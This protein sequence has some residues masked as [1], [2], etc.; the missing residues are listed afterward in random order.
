MSLLNWT[1][2]WRS[3]PTIRRKNNRYI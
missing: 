3:L 2:S 1:K